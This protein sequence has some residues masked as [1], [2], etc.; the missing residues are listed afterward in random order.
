MRLCDYHSDFTNPETGMGFHYFNSL[1]GDWHTHN[2][3]E[4]FIVTEGTLLQHINDHKI[5]MKKGDLCIVRP[6]DVHVFFE[7]D[8][9]EAQHINIMLTT[10]KMETFANFIGED[11]LYPCDTEEED[12]QQFLLYYR[13]PSK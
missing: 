5:I 1:Y 6:E 11:C 10:E 13:E 2:Y 9:Q 7:I 3:W 4:I 12:M 8:G